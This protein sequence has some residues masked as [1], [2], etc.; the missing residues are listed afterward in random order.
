MLAA[1]LSADKGN[2]LKEDSAE[3]FMIRTALDQHRGQAS[4]IASSFWNAC[5]SLNRQI[6]E[7]YPED[8]A[9]IALKNTLYTSVEEICEQDDLVRTRIAKLAALET[10]Q[11]P[12]KED[13]E[14]L[15]K[16]P[17]SNFLLILVFS[18]KLLK[19]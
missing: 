3:T 12:T 19:L 15:K 16:V 1:A 7:I 13:R 9:L 5:M 8:S 18:D 10:R 11:Y 4:I 2:G 14:D 6:G 17:E